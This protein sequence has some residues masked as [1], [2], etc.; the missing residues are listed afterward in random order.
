MRSWSM[1]R[2]AAACL[3]ACFLLASATGT[4]WA[5][6]KNPTPTDIAQAKTHMK[7]GVTM[8]DDPAGPRYEEAYEEFRKAHLL[9]GS[10][11]AL[12]NMGICAQNLELDGEAIRSYQKFL[13]LKGDDPTLKP[14]IKERTQRDLQALKSVVAWVTIT[15]DVE[16]M[17]LTD[18]RVQRRGMPITNT[19]STMTMKQT[20]GIH[21]GRHK[22]T[23]STPGLEDQ[24]WEVTIG[25]GSKHAHDFDFRPGGPVHSDQ[26][27]GDGN[28]LPDPDEKPDEK[29]DTGTDTD[30]EG[31][32]GMTIA[33]GVVGGLTGALAVPTIIFMV[34]SGSAK[35]DH[36][37]AVEARSPDEAQLRDD[38]E[39][40]NLIADI[41][42]AATAT[43]AAA[44]IVLA[45]LAATSEDE[46][47]DASEPTDEESARFGVD[48]TLAPSVDPRGGGGALFTA[49][50]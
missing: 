19:Y 44:T 3:A 42:L 10:A 17:T 33:A 45:I 18:Q 15:T 16:N 29:P 1:I 27:P 2:Y 31:G 48:W 13:K 35:A 36:D 28:D 50:F 43:G 4:A 49:H 23:A 7:A 12:L 20:L 6:K 25:N 30:T 9:S 34:Q 46:T 24:V 32:S 11:N 38:L 22:F 5:Q 26:D 39:T 37:A 47:A 40:T 41:F 8:M 21:P 14:A